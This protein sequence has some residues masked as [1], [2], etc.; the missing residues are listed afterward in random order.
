MVLSLPLL[1]IFQDILQNISKM[2]ISS[3]SQSGS[4]WMRAPEEQ[5]RK[6]GK[7]LHTHEESHGRNISTLNGSYQRQASIIFPHG[8]VAFASEFYKTTQ[9]GFQKCL[10]G[11]EAASSNTWR[12]QAG[13]TASEAG[14]VGNRKYSVAIWRWWPVPCFSFADP[15]PNLL[16]FQVFLTKELEIY[17]L[18]FWSFKMKATYSKWVQQDQVDTLPTWFSLFLQDV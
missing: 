3:C 8:E 5:D 11:A 10:S 13:N 1:V 18:F 6:A 2:Q 4:N 9:K 17:F 14:V 16:A 7:F 12:G 15:N